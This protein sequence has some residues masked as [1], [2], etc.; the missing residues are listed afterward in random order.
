MRVKGKGRGAKVLKEQRQKQNQKGQSNDKTVSPDLSAIGT[1]SFLEGLQQGDGNPL[2]STALEEDLTDL[3]EEKTSRGKAERKEIPQTKKKTVK[4]AGAAA[5]RKEAERDGEEEEERE[6]KR[7]RRSSGARP[8]D[9]QQ[10]KKGRK[11]SSESGGGASRESESQEE[12]DDASPQRSRRRLLSSEDEDEEQS[13]HPSP[14][15]PRMNGFGRTRKSSSEKSKS[16]KSSSEKSKSRK[17]SSEKSKSRKSSSGSSSAEPEKSSENQ[18]RRRGGTQL[19]VVLDAF[20]DFCQ[21]YRQSVESTSVKKSIDSFSSNVEEHILEK[22]ASLKELKVLKRENAKVGSLIRTKTQRLLEAKHEQMRAERQL[23]LLQKEK[24]E[25]EVR[26][27]DLRRGR[28]FLQDIRELHRQY[29]E[30][31]HTQPRGEETYGAS[32]LPALLL[33]T[34]LQSI[35]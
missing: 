20:L 13:W 32:C 17:S 27:S 30:H 10:I 2:H 22:V 16:R 35:S 11:R 8:M 25:L 24:T 3:E 23:S 34:K 6:K 31:R 18:R 19:E 5:K 12:S 14:E 21:Q 28:A 15:K 26:L 4:Q 29:L 9:N 1:S 7:G 33:E